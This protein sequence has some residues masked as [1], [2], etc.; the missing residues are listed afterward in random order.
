[1][2]YL[3]IASFGLLAACSTPQDVRS[4]LKSTCEGYG[5]SLGTTAFAQCMQSE[6]QARDARRARMSQALGNMSKPSPMITCRDLG[7]GVTQCS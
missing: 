4:Q 5:F 1:M 3:I 6:A 7:G 2:R